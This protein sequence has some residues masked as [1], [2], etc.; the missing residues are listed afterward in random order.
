MGHLYEFNPNTNTVNDGSGLFYSGTG[1]AY[2]AD[3]YLEK[4]T[5]RLT[6]WLSYG[7]GYTYRKFPD[8]NQGRP[9]FPKYDRRHSFNLVATYQLSKSWKLNAAWSY[10]TGQA[11]TRATSQYEIQMPDRTVPIIIGEQRNISRLPPY[12]RMDLGVRYAKVVNTKILKQWGFYLQIFNLYN[13][14]NV[15]FRYVDVEQQ[16]PEALEIRMLPIIPTIGFE[17]H[18]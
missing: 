15:W 8:L 9:Y 3:F 14:R 12:H 11:Y 17:F 2:G 10:G 7:L 13:R 6:G 18:F 4:N 1:Y 5:G 16:P